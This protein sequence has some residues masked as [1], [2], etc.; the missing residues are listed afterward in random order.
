MAAGALSIYSGC[1]RA[2]FQSSRLGMEA[3]IALME[4][5][6]DTPAC[7]I[8]LSGNQAV[9]LPLMECVE[10]VSHAFLLYDILGDEREVVMVFDCII[11]CRQSW[12]RGPCT[13][14]SLTR[15]S[16]CVEGERSDMSCVEFSV[17]T[18]NLR[19]VVPLFCR[20]FEN[21]WN[22]YKL[23]AYQKPVQ[24]EV[25]TQVQVLT[26]CKVSAQLLMVALCFPP[27]QFHLGHSECGSSSCRDERSGEVCSEAGNHSWPQGLLCP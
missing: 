2:R 8:G 18:G 12:C 23:L 14:G 3:V 11:C 17:S 15:R 10:M 20:S 6:P 7:V 13:K 25:K 9:R 26:P 24:T 21:N 4:A 19:F 27:D 16:N 1:V 5:S 22:I